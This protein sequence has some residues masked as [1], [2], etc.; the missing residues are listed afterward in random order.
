MLIFLPNMYKNAKSYVRDCSKCSECFAFKTGV[1]HRENISSLIFCILLNQLTVF[2]SKAK[3][4][5]YQ[6]VFKVK[7]RVKTWQVWGIWFQELEHKQF[8]K[9][10]TEQGI[11]K[12]KRSLLACQTRCKCSMETTHYSVKVKLGIKIMKLV[13]SLTGWGVTVGQGSEWHLTF[14]RGRLHSAE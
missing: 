5:K 6:G 4:R 12:G 7:I 3:S 14:V 13:Q 11:R 10:G 2:M 1:R 9:R 8:P